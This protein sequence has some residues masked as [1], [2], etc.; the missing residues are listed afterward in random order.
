LTRSRLGD[1]GGIRDVEP[2]YVEGGVFVGD[3][4]ENANAS[5]RFKRSVHG[6]SA[7]PM[8]DLTDRMLT[9]SRLEPTRRLGYLSEREFGFALA[10]YCLLREERSPVWAAEVAPA[11]RSALLQGLRWYARR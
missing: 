9:G 3:A 6:W 7:L 10:G 4:V 5:Y 11:V 1:R 2:Q 8:G